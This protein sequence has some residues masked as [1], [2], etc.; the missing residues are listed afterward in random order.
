MSTMSDVELI[1]KFNAAWLDGDLETVLSCVA[2]DIVYSTSGSGGAQATTYRGRPE[3]AAVFAEHIG[4]DPQLTLGPVAAGHGRALCDWWYPMAEDG[5]SLRGVDVY[6][7]RDGL[8]RRKDVF[9][10]NGR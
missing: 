7:I 6:V 2:D 8:I 1:Q 10:K 9:A 5:T 4:H 3:V